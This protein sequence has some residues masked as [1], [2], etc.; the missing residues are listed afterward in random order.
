[1][2]LLHLSGQVLLL[3]VVTS[4]QVAGP[5]NGQSEQFLD[6][7]YKRPSLSSSASRGTQCTS[8]EPTEG[9]SSKLTG[10]LKTTLWS[11]ST[12]LFLLLTKMRA[13]FSV[14]IHPHAPPFLPQEP[15]LGTAVCPGQLPSTRCPRRL[16]AQAALSKLIPHA[17]C[18]PLSEAERMKVHAQG[19]IRMNASN[20]FDR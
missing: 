8:G 2:S 6:T 12:H 3:H 11:C 7:S 4:V 9:L 1:M 19:C 15:V 5:T 18:L 17:D 13:R 14:W 10:S 20:L 16:G